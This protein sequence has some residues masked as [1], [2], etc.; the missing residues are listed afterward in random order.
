MQI[1]GN[2][3]MAFL[4][5]PMK[6]TP[7]RRCF[8]IVLRDEAGSVFH[9]TSPESQPPIMAAPDGS[10]MALPAEL[11]PGSVINVMADVAGDSGT[12]TAVQVVTA[13]YNNPFARG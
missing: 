1:Q 8:A 3:M 12:M 10:P 7:D 2:V 11:L 4:H 5:R 6:L 9:L 13:K